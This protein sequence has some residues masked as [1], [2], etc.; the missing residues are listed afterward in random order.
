[1]PMEPEPDESR[2]DFMD[3]C[4]IE[5]ADENPSWDEN[6]CFAAC[7]NMW[8]DRDVLYRTYRSN[9]ADGF[10]FVLSDATPDRVGDVIM[11]TGWDLRNFNNNP[12]ALFNHHPDFP[13]G[14]WRNLRVERDG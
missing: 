9:A 5:C 1:M 3:R 11:A 2:D 4:V 13:I 8:E 10:T 6:E 14:M 7:E 12:V